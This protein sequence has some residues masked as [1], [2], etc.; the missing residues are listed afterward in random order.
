M[1]YGNWEEIISECQFAFTESTHPGYR[2]NAGAILTLIPLIKEHPGFRDLTPGVSHTN[3]FFDIPDKQTRVYVW[4]EGGFY[5][6]YHYDP[7]LDEDTKIEIFDKREK[8]DL[9]AV[10]AVLGEKIEKIRNGEEYS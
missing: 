9:A 2:E 3:L 4:Y 8:A 5:G 1:A 7:D 10:V 6:I